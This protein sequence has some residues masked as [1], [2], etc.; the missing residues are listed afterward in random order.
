MAGLVL[1]AVSA[2]PLIEGVFLVSFPEIA[3]ALTLAGVG[4]WLCWSA[5]N[6]SGADD[7]RPGQGLLARWLQFL[8]V[9]IPVV[10]LAYVLGYV[11]FMDR[12]SPTDPKGEFKMAEPRHMLMIAGAFASAPIGLI[13]G[14]I[15]IGIGALLRRS[16]A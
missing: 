2:S 10:L 15:C 7:A 11:A 4:W 14:S 13:L 6:R 9:A 1:L 5:A 16:N 12:Q 3:I 8:T